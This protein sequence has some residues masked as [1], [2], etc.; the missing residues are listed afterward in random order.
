MYLQYKKSGKWADYLYG[1]RI[2]MLLSLVTQT[3]IAWQ[4][5]AGALRP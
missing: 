4:I 3:L 2:Y 1:E 5:F